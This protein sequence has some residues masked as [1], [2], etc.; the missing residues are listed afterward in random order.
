[1]KTRDVVWNGNVFVYSI[2]DASRCVNCWFASWKWCSGWPRSASGG[3]S[4]CGRRPGS[5]GRLN[6]V[7]PRCEHNHA[8]FRRRRLQQRLERRPGRLL[9]RQVH[10]SRQGHRQ[11]EQQT[12][13][14]GRGISGYYLSATC[15]LAGAG[16]A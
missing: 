6:A 3:R 1:M 12:H 4:G 15:A 13:P 2:V 16:D 11:G 10:T 7:L 5:P 8:R 9:P 14:L